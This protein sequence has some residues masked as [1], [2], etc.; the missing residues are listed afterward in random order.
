MARCSRFEILLELELK[1]Q[2][3]RATTHDRVLGAIVRVLKHKLEPEPL[4]IESHGFA[5]V[6]SGQHGDR[7]STEKVLRHPRLLKARA[8]SRR[9]IGSKSA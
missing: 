2:L 7:V 9:A 1:V 6:P 8:A 4:Y 5:Q 3:H